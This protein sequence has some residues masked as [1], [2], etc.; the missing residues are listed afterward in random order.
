MRRR[1]IGKALAAVILTGSLVLIAAPGAQ[2]GGRWGV[3]R[4]GNVPD[5]FCT[6]CGAPPQIT[7]QD[8][9]LMRAAH[10]GI[11]R[12]FLSWPGIQPN[13]HGA[14][15]WAPIDQA[16]GT[17][18]SRGIPALPVL[19][20]SPSYAASNPVRPPLDSSAAKSEWKTFV[21]AA[22]NRYGQGGEYWTNPLLF[23]SQF[24]GHAAVP[25]KFWQIWNEENLPR[26]LISSNA[27]RDYARLL[28]LTHQ[29]IKGADPQAKVVLG[30]MPGYAK[31]R[32]W[33]FLKHLYRVH[34]VKR[35]FEAGALHPY[36][37]TQHLVAFQ[38]N[39]YR[40]VMDRNHDARTP[41]WFTEF[42]WGSGDP[43]GA[44]NRGPAGQAQSLKQS[45]G[46]FWR[47]RRQWHLQRVIWYDWIDPPVR[48]ECG[49]NNFC[50]TAGLLSSDYTPKPAY[51]A[52]QQFAANH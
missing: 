19:F 27:P 34:G 44:I 48:G 37:A 9:D 2:A 3:Q 35:Y 12:I 13:E 50:D 45:F 10:V 51:S 5:A 16:V 11:V 49:G 1:R 41:I 24:P 23:Q 46:T 38:V 14:Y 20:G 8:A 17:L 25:V 42:A 29:A 43:D 52:F 7:Q 22:V 39:K 40:Q 18:A 30:G 4:A 6:Y 47:K 28:K 33:N 36:A 15:D 21:S 26:Y 32:S 31:V